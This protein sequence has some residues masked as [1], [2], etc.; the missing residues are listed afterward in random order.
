MSEASLPS[1]AS[2]IFGLQSPLLVPP[3][4]ILYPSEWILGAKAIGVMFLVQQSPPAQ[5]VY[6]ILPSP[7]HSY[8][9]R[10]RSQPDL[11]PG[12]LGI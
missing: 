4:Y 6:K 9:T 2:L 8:V 5:T 11:A 12:L 10:Y 3:V 1:R 7:P